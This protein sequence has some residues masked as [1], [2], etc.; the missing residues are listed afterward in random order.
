MK[1]RFALALW[2]ALLIACA[3]IISQARITADM[4]AFLPRLSTPAQQMMADQLRAGVASRLMLVAIEGAAPEALAKASQALTRQLRRNNAFSYVNNGE[5]E[6]SQRDRDFLFAHRYLLSEAVT[7]ERFSSAGLAQSL[8]ADLSLLGTPAGVLV[9]RLLPQDPTGELLHIVDA[10]GAERHPVLRHGVWFSADGQHALLLAQTRAPGFDT[11]RQSEAIAALHSAFNSAKTEVDAAAARLVMTGPGVFAV[12]ARAAIEHDAWRFSLITTI[13]AAGLLLFA[14]RSLKVLGLA[15]LPVASGAAAGVAAVALAFGSVH[16]VTLGFGATLIGE[17]VDYAIYLFTH[18]RAGT[19]AQQSLRRIWPTLRLGMVT[20]VCGFSALLFSGFPGL[21]QLGLFS[22]AGLLVA[23]AVTRWVLPALLPPAFA[24]I[25]AERL[26]DQALA[27]FAQAHKL[28]PLLLLLV[29]AAGG[30][31]LLQSQPAWDDDLAKLSPILATDKAIDQRLRAEIA[32][33]DVGQLLIASGTSQDEAL[34]AAERAAPRLRELVAQGALAGFDSPARYL[35]SRATQLAR[36]A[37]LP[38]PAQLRENL[39]AAVAQSAFQPDLFEPFLA[40]AATAKTGPLLT[41]DDLRATSLALKVDGLLLQRGDVW[42]ALLPLHGLV[43]P[44]RVKQSI[45]SLNDPRITLL[46]MKAESDRLVSRYRGET[47]LLSLMG[48]AVIVALLA[49]SLRSAQRIYRVLAPLAAAVVVVCCLLL[50]SGVRLS[51][52]HLVGLLLV[53]AIGSNYSL[54]FDRAGTPDSD[55]RR[56]LLALL[57]ACSTTVI[58]FGLLALSSTPVLH[59]IGTTV[60]MGVT[61]SLLFS[62]IL[63]SVPKVQKI[64]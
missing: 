57:L 43:D 58:A 32:A 9:K 45:A 23:L 60:A 54:F 41:R 1:F 20:S 39:R 16:G 47:L 7:P 64:Q 28:R 46:D 29:L 3:W 25:Q 2:L 12:H 4:T 48:G 55:P 17:A 10:L 27:L 62:A 14:Y 51:L 53:V 26:A 37:A 6:W 63:A 21:A 36:Q 18:L 22:I 8:D 34:V 30:Y 50:L 59:A 13:M 11:D 38:A 56:M 35:P 61:L 5:P 33:P 31:L 42:L 19:T 24:P 44:G 52:L 40:Q 49:F 15:L